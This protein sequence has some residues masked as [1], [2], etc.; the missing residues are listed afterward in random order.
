M[1][2]RKRETTAP[3]PI[4]PAPHP[5]P[6]RR[7][8]R[9]RR[10]PPAR[11]CTAH[12]PLQH[13]RLQVRGDLRAGRVEVER[14]AALARQQFHHMQAIAAFQRMLQQPGRAAQQALLE[15]GD[16]LPRLDP[17]EVAARLLR[18][19]GGETPGQVDEAL[20]MPAQLVEQLRGLLARRLAAFQVVR[21]AGQQHMAQL[22]APGAEQASR[23]GRVPGP[24]GVFVG[25]RDLHLFLQQLADARF[26]RRLAVFAAASMPSASARCRSNWRTISARQAASSASA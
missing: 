14:L 24:A 10:L 11:R 4:A 25:F 15:F 5:R 3:K 23:I 22:Q 17:A 13:L 2:G 8:P 18:R 16:G 12:G 19:T 26:L 21:R 1:C 7:S 9:C 6:R 20:G